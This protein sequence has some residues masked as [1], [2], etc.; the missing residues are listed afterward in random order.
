MSRLIDSPSK[1][2]EPVVNTRNTDKLQARF[3]H[4]QNSLKR[5]RERF[6]DHNMRTF[7][8][9]YEHFVAGLRGFTTKRQTT[10][11]RSNSETSRKNK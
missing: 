1:A 3:G 4:F 9:V 5:A 11:K 6:R 7:P 10:H 2:F 8:L